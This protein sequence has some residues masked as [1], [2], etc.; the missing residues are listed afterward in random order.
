MLN[1]AYIYW[2]FATCKASC[3]MHCI[4][5]LICTEGEWKK[6]RKAASIY[7]WAP[8]RDWFDFDSLT[9]EKE[10][11]QLWR[12]ICDTEPG[13]LQLG[14]RP[15]FPL[16]LPP[17]DRLV[18]NMN[19]QCR[20]TAHQVHQVPAERENCQ[21][22]T[23]FLQRAQIRHSNMVTS[24]RLGYRWPAR[25]PRNEGSLGHRSTMF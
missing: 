20:Q 17:P 14:H 15:G 4:N 8:E 9:I 1:V 21:W 16:C 12:E 22:K 10:P 2:K 24:A 25:T 23:A 19:W 13:S 6:N 5:Y 7:S 18:V 11:K 3:Y